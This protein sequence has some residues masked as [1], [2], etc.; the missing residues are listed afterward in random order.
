VQLQPAA[1]LLQLLCIAASSAQLLLLWGLLLCSR[2]LHAGCR[3]RWRAAHHGAAV[4]PRQAGR[5]CALA[6]LLLLLLLLLLL[7]GGQQGMLLG[8][9][10]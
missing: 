6:A 9:P 8:W 7:C 4:T 10:Q 1:Q 3:A 5:R 2:W